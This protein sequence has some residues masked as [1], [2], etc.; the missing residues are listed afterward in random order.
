MIFTLFCF[1][2]IK[3]KSLMTLIAQLYFVS[4]VK[5]KSLTTLTMLFYFTDIKM[6]SLTTITTLSYLTT[7]Q[8]EFL[9][10]LTPLFYFVAITQ[11]KSLTTLNMLGFFCHY[12]ENALY[13]Y[14]HYSVLLHYY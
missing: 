14:A 7:I 13:D 3:I 10:R 1:T 5:R 2:A 12:Y 4:T 9:W 8:M 6:K 11:M